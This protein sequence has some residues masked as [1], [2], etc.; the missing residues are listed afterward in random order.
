M[1]GVEGDLCTVAIS[2]CSFGFTSGLAFLGTYGG[3]GEV[4]LMGE[5]LVVSLKAM[6]LDE[7]DTC[8]YW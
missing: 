4:L 1:G 2:R 3:T 5:L 7:V 8:S 6:S